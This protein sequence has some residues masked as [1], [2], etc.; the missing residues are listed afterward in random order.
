[1]ATREFQRLGIVDKDYC[2]DPRLSGQPFQPQ[3]MASLW[4]QLVAAEVERLERQPP[5]DLGRGRDTKVKLMSTKPTDPCC[6]PRC[7][8][9]LL[10]ALRGLASNPRN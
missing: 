10:E 6:S 4:L 1:M 5:M 8:Y 2:L 9:V 3:G 7:A